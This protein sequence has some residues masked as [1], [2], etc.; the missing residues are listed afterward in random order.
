MENSKLELMTEL[1][2][3]RLRLNTA[4]RERKETDDKCRKLEVNFDFC[5]KVHFLKCFIL[6]YQS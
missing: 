5:V 4:E 6:Y 2:N 3:L 1:S